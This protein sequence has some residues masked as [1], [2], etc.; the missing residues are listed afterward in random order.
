MG[1][2]EK[3]LKYKK[4]INETGKDTLIDKIKGPAETEMLKDDM[5][6]EETAVHESEAEQYPPQTE[7]IDIAAEEEPVLLG[8]D[9]FV[10]ENLPPLDDA[11]SEDE[12]EEDILSLDSED[13]TEVMDEKLT[14]ET[15]EFEEH[16]N[17]L[18]RDEVIEEEPYDLPESHLKLE[19][20]SEIKEYQDEDSPEEKISPAAIEDEDL[21][22]EDE[23]PRFYN[24]ETDK[25]EK[26]DLDT[27]TDFQILYN[28]QKDISRASNLKELFDEI[29]FTVM[30]QFGVSSASVMVKSDDKNWVVIET[31]GI[32]L[33]EKYKYFDASDR[34]IEYLIDNDEIVE[35]DEFTDKADYR[36]SYYKFIGIDA[37]LLV[38]MRFDKIITGIIIVGEKLDSTNYTS[39]E[40]EF[41]KSISEISSTVM[42]R[43]N[44]IQTLANKNEEL[45]EKMNEI[46]SDTLF[47]EKVQNC[48][49]LSDARTVVQD[50]FGKDGLV[51]Y[52]IFILSEKRDKFYPVVCE[53]EDYLSLSQTG[54]NINNPSG[55]I[56]YLLKNDS[57]V[58]FDDIKISA[59]L[60]DFFDN[61]VL[62]KMDML[63]I[64]PLQLGNSLTGFISL[65]RLKEGLNI[66]LVDMKLQQTAK[67]LIPYLA[68]IR[69]NDIVEN[70]YVDTIEITYRR[71]EEELI[72]A[73]KLGIPLTLVLFSI[74]NFKRY[75]SLFGRNV[76]ELL[77]D[78]FEHV[79]FSK[80]SDYDFSVRFDRQKI[81][82]VLP[83]K[84]RKYA[85]PLANAIRNEVVHSFSKREMQLLLTYL[86]SSYP[87]DG[88]DLHSLLDCID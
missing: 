6:D 39:S 49:G 31:R 12:T 69:K 81:L 22:P 60:R 66:E 10:Y 54:F 56:K 24:I 14:D 57:P 53:Q 84:D 72:R 87:E 64:Y 9:D 8:P 50:E 83:G 79:I 78:R 80:L 1:L 43:I 21:I 45:T 15:E 41:L 26:G 19:E 13:L 68:E 52:G 33:D 27:E 4:E 58:V 85:V 28:V 67:F 88:E 18:I 16:E 62:T 5:A 48:A 59:F 51:S 37:M 34:I 75:Y 73:Q 29:L 61:A 40:R 71:I 42:Y 74:K 82:L 17:T 76:A 46:E 65:F 36:D 47:I 32:T 23:R 86:T 63:R 30:G 7:S 38:P 70:R 35:T 11:S 55:F 2:L 3:A 77:L 20:S 44:S 25:N